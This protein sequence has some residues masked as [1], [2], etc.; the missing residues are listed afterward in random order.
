MWDFEKEGFYKVLENKKINK[1][2]ISFARLYRKA[3]CKIQPAC[4]L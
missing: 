1:M 4:P 2:K 3:W